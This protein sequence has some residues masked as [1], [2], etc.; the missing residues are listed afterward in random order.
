MDKRIRDAHNA[1]EATPVAK[2]LADGSISKSVYRQYLE[3]ALEIWKALDRR[4]L[5]AGQLGI[6]DR[7]MYD[8]RRLGGP[9]FGPTPAARRHAENAN[10]AD[11][12]TLGLGLCYG[13]KIMARQLA[14]KDLPASHMAGMPKWAISTLKNI[15]V[16]Q[17][18]RVRAFQ[19]AAGWYQDGA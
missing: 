17:D 2:A 7:L 6:A 13:G 18:E 4:Y 9:F 1:I 11:M 19:D 15:N 3:N 16:S 5:L 14:D 8:L 12:R 10:D